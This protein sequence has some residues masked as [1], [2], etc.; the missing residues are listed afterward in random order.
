MASKIESRCRCGKS[1][2]VILQENNCD[3]NSNCTA[4]W[5]D[6]SGNICGEWLDNHPSSAAGNMFYYYHFPIHHQFFFL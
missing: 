1:Y 4:Q 5:D 6:N 2:E 3:E